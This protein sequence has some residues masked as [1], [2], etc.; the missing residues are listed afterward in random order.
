MSEQVSATGAAPEPPRISVIMNCYNSARFLRAAIDS[1]FAQTYA[2]WEI[3]FWD[4]QST[5]DSAAIFK[6]YVDPRC[7]YF[8]APV[9]TALGQA[10]NL[11]VAQ[12]RGEWCAFLDCDDLWLAEKLSRQVAIIDADGSSLGLVYGHMRILL[13]EG[14]KDSPWRQ[15][16]QKF[17]ERA[18]FPR[19]PEGDIFNELLKSDFIPMPSAMFLR[20]AF[21]AVNGIDPSF[22]SAED[23]DLFVKIAR[24]HRVRAVQDVICLYRVHDGN[25][26]PL[27]SDVGFQ[28]ELTVVSRYLPQPAARKALRYHH[29]YQAVRMIKSHKRFL[30]LCYLLRHGDVRVVF[31]EFI[32]RRLMTARVGAGS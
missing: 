7:R 13:D 17:V 29:T 4:N 23:F 12:A 20:S 27:L 24:T 28:E 21:I 25:L 8:L 1:V 5:D 11:A 10:R 3:V 19:M 32:K 14:E 15:S 22:R 2:D 26:T 6:S 31:S 16:M 30:G 18:R 9:H